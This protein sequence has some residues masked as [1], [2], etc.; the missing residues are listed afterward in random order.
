MTKLKCFTEYDIRG[1]P[2]DLNIDIAYLIGLAYAY[3][4]NPK[5][6]IVGYDVRLSSIALANAVIRGLTDSGV[7]IINIG[8][9]GTE[10]VYFH[11]FS[12]EN[13]R[14]HGGIMI[15]ASHNPKNYHGIKMVKSSAQPI[16]ST[17]DLQKIHDQVLW[18]LQNTKNTPKT[19]NRKGRIL[20]K[21]DKSSYISH[22]LSYIDSKNLMPL[23]ILV[24]PGNG[25]AGEVIKLL[26]KELPFQ[27]IYIHDKPDG[28]FPN[29]V[30]NPMIKENRIVTSSAIIAHNADCGIAWDSDFDR[31]FLFDEQGQF[32]ESYYLINILAK[33]LL[34]QSSPG[35]KVV[36]DPRLI[37]HTI[38][39]VENHGGVAV[40]SKSGHNFMKA[41][42]RE[43]DAIYGGEIS[44][45]HYFRNFSYCDSGMIPWLIITE[46]LC[47]DNIKLSH[48]ARDNI[49]FFRCSGELNYRVKNVKQS[50]DNVKQYFALQGAKIYHIDGISVEFI[51]WRF[52]LRRSNTEP[53]LRLNLE[54]KGDKI[55]IDSKVAEVE[56][57]I[58]N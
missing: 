33:T 43:V 11:T 22:I 47:K 32:I 19:L 31:C 28:N 40:A 29:G 6:V 18:Y 34:S 24:N 42:M 56:S 35:E 25:S 57:L 26:A 5:I 50:I 14:I 1:E 16:S 38:N 36:H 39:T 41:K 45:H 37:W 54:I 21:K 46:L 17:D 55:S 27:F 49:S 20:Y 4:L 7:D 53:L 51:D 13:D 44:A 15:T 58:L 8:L 12:K 48:L 9:C 2:Q 23:K 3:I 10:E 30:P 52:N